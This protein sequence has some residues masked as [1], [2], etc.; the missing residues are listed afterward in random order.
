MFGLGH[1]YGMKTQVA[2]ELLHEMDGRHGQ[3]D[4]V[5]G[6]RHRLGMCYVIRPILSWQSKDWSDIKKE[7]RKEIEI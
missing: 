1:G 2:K 3:V 4:V 7:Y 5:M 6:R